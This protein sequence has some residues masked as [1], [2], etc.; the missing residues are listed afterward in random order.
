MKYYRQATIQDGL[1]VARNLR[2][3]DRQE[4]EGLGHSPLHI[5]VGIVTSEQAISFHNEH[6]DLAGVAGIVRLDNQVGQIWMLC[7]PVIQEGPQRFVRGA[8]R[9]LNEV[10]KEYALL[11]NLADARNHMHHKLLK[12]LGF[13]ALQTVHVGPTNLPYYEIVKLCA[14]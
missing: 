14:F 2:I 4:V 5:P 10:E 8:K 12:L 3:E 1:M 13:Q 11:W 7:T 6:G 9:W